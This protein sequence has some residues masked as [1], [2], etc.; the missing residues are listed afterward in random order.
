MATALRDNGVPALLVLIEGEGHGFRS[1]ATLVR[2]LGA[3]LA[4]YGRALGFE[5]AG[6]MSR[7]SS[8]LEAAAAP[9]GSTWPAGPVAP[10]ASLPARGR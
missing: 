10:E 7:A 5:P 3:E 8:D 6:D 9:R 4:F 1:E 2:A